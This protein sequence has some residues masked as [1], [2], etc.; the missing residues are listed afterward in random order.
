MMKTSRTTLAIALM[1]ALAACSSDDG[2]DGNSSGGGSDAVSGDSS[3]G[4]GSDAMAGDGSAGGSDAMAEDGSG[5]GEGDGSGGGGEDAGG[6]EDVISVSDALA[7]LQSNCGSELDACNADAGCKAFIDCVTACEDFDCTES[8]VEPD[9]EA[10][11]S[12]LEGVGLCGTVNECLP[13][14]EQNVTPADVVACIDEA[15]SDEAAACAADTFCNDTRTCFATCDTGDCVDNTC[16]PEDVTPSEAFGAWI[17]C[18][19]DAGCVPNDGA[20]D[21]VF[22]ECGAEVLA[23]FNEQACVDAFDCIDACDETSEDGCELACINALSGDA[24]AALQAVFSCV[25]D[26]CSDDGGDGGGE[27]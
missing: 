14:D 11:L 4:G 16:L 26:K 5:G 24:E 1:A 21:C 27:G 23:C 20:D 13:D 9:G 8:C 10:G 17:S 7:C 22:D 19:D 12:L 15:C 18:G 25:S 3:G 6:G 2:G